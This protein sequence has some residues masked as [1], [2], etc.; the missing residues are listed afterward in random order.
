MTT[1]TYLVI[2]DESES[3]QAALLFASHA[4]KTAQ[5]NVAILCIVEPEEIQAWGGVERA[6]D[7]EAFDAARLAMA[8]HEKV[9]EAITGQKPVC[10]YR[11]GGR[12]AVLA[13]YL[14][15]T[16]GIR[17]LVLGA[18]GKNTTQSHLIAHMA[19]EKNLHKLSLPLIIVPIK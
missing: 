8:A 6:L 16:E 13:D 7:D 5:A 1:P 2:K 19:A 18:G 15:Q 11:K 12:R 14:E 4:A 9:A 10:V 17:A 3:F